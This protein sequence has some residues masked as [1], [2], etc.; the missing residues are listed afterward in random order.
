MPQR[1]GEPE[2]FSCIHCQD[3]TSEPNCLHVKQVIMGVYLVTALEGLL[4]LVGYFLW[5]WPSFLSVL[6]QRMIF[7]YLLTLV[8]TVIATQHK[9]V[10]Q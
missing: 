3:V 5:F 10:E 6:I 4:R 8:P 2:A 7:F 9:D 1:A